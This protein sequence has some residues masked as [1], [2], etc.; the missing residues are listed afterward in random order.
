MATLPRDVDRL[1]RIQL[2]ISI[3]QPDAGPALLPRRTMDLEAAHD[4]RRLCRATGGNS[5]DPNRVFLDW[6]S[7]YRRGRPDRARGRRL[8]HGVP[9]GDGPY[10]LTHVTSWAPAGTLKGRRGGARWLPRISL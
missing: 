3:K 1:G 7:Q 10:L 2:G 6:H 4:E 5:R 8:E 9:G